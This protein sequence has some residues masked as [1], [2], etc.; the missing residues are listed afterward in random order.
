[1]RTNI[2]SPMIRKTLSLG[3]SMRNSRSSFQSPWFGCFTLIPQV[4]SAKDA[5]TGAANWN[6]LA[7][8][9]W[10]FFHQTD[11]FCVLGG[12]A[13]WAKPSLFERSSGVPDE[14]TTWTLEAGSPPAFRLLS[15]NF[16]WAAKRS[17][18]VH[19]QPVCPDENLGR[20]HEFTRFSPMFLHF[21]RI[22][23]QNRAR[24]RVKVRR[25]SRANGLCGWCS[26]RRRPGFSLGL[27]RDSCL[28]KNLHFWRGKINVD[29]Q[30]IVI[31]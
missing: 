11:G 21:S 28:W 10:G 12:M 22:F 16:F 26:I 8:V 13:V 14:K 29:F 18:G 3:K 4:D 19:S 23:P 7:L 31:F 6:M 20:S 9:G 15:P 24:K 25:R 17:F 2:D 1:M 27:S 5:A 30:S